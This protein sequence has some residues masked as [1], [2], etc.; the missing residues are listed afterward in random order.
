M[1]RGQASE[2]LLY[3][4]GGIITA[5]VIYYG[6][7]AI[8]S[9]MGKGE[10]AQFLLLKQGITNDIQRITVQAGAARNISYSLSAD[11]N[12][13]C[14]VDTSKREDIITNPSANKIINDSVYSNSSNNVF[15][16]GQ[17]TEAFNAGDLKVCN[18]SVK[19][20]QAYAGKAHVEIYGGGGFALFDP[21]EIITNLP[22]YIIN[23][24]AKDVL[25]FV[26]ST[27]S[28]PLSNISIAK[29]IDPEG[30]VMQIIWHIKNASGN[31]TSTLPLNDIQSGSEVQH[32][33]D[34][35]YYGR[36]KATVVA[37]DNLGKQGSLDF[38][39][40]V[41][42]PNN[43]PPEAN[44]TL[45]T[46]LEGYS[47]GQMISFM[48]A[49]N[50]TEGGALGYQWDFGDSLPVQS[51]SEY[52]AEHQQFTN[53]TTHSFLLSGTY[54]VMFTVTDAGGLSDTSVRTITIGNTLPV[55]SIILPEN[56]AVVNTKDVNFTFTPVDREQEKMTCLIALINQTGGLRRITLGEVLNF[57][58]ASIIEN[59]EEGSYTWTASCSDGIGT[60]TSATMRFKVILLPLLRCYLTAAC[61]VLFSKMFSLSSI[62]NAHASQ[63][64]NDMAYTQKVCC[65]LTK[66]ATLLNIGP[67][68]VTCYNQDKN[69]SLKLSSPFNAHA[70]IPDTATPYYSSNICLKTS[71]P[72]ISFLC[73]S[74]NGICDQIGETCVVSLS[75]DT[76]AHLE[77]CI[78][79][80]Y[81][82]KICCRA[83]QT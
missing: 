36:Y 57:T 16:L 30:S 53:T 26:D 78:S 60:G 63:D 22:P 14:Y 81:P 76:N 27:I 13:I 48:A 56:N 15:L 11:F 5:I 35:T 68:T 64:P 39:I 10:E 6:V 59:L 51:G 52:R 71:E 23:L 4:A 44:I 18:S 74:T 79:G 19:C 77:S 55:I 28:F 58:N 12:E 1:K 54:N 33:L 40:A 46:D 83:V 80:N 62:T 17:K 29:V 9:F 49:G 70:E 73:R 82:V 20:F 47:P 69:M 66:G 43:E 8:I 72:G 21:C 38:N 7:S 61:P 41:A 67:N 37:T 3:I 31:V 34:I 42:Q 45:P 25:L 32:D 24:T 65:N 2:T 75:S 50:D